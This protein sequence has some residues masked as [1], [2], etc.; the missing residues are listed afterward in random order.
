MLNGPMAKRR[1]ERN[2]GQWLQVGETT[3][4]SN[5]MEVGQSDDEVRPDCALGANRTNH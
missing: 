2:H 3:G 4:K 5:Q 1:R